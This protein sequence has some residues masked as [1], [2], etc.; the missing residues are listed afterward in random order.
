MS[1]KQIDKLIT[2]TITNSVDSYN[3]ITSPYTVTLFKKVKGNNWLISQKELDNEKYYTYTKQLLPESDTLKLRID[4]ISELK[5]KY[6]TDFT[7]NFNTKITNNNAKPKINNITAIVFDN[8]YPLEVNEYIEETN[9]I[10][11]GLFD[12][13]LT[14]EEIYDAIQA[15]EFWIELNF[16]GN[17]S[18]CKLEINNFNVKIGFTNDLEIEKEAIYNRLEDLFDDIDLNIDTINRTVYPENYP[19][20][21]LLTTTYEIFKTK[22][23]Q[24][25]LTKNDIGIENASIECFINDIYIGEPILTGTDG[26]FNI[27][28][29]DMVDDFNIKCIFKGNSLMGSA[30]LNENISI[31][32]Y[33][34]NFSINMEETEYIF[35]PSQKEPI[36]L[37]CSFNK[38]RSI[39]DNNPVNITCS[40][41]NK[42]NNKTL[43]S[44]KFK[45]VTGDLSINFNTYNAT[46]TSN[47]NAKVEVKLEGNDKYN[48]VVMS[49]D[50]S[51]K[52]QTDITYVEKTPKISLVSNYNN[53]GDRLY[54]KVTDGSTVIKCGTCN[55]TINGKTI[56]NITPNENGNFVTG[57]LSTY[58]IS[59]LSTDKKYPCKVIYSGCNHKKDGVNTIYKSVNMSFDLNVYG[60][61]TKTVPFTKYAGYEEN[62]NDGGYRKWYTLGSGDDNICI[63]GNASNPIGASGGTH[64]YPRQLACYGV[65]TGLSNVSIKG[66]TVTYYDANYPKTDSMS[67]TNSC[68]ISKHKNQCTLIMDTASKIFTDKVAIGN[69]S[70]SKHSFSVSGSWTPS[71]LNNLVMILYYGANVN[72]N[73]GRLKVAG[74]CV[75]LTYKYSQVITG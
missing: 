43:N 17:G 33:T 20:I 47:I 22:Y 51:L 46:G 71:Q 18:N 62:T 74:A 10:E 59:N 1:Q 13:D 34:A 44:L 60:E 54:F 31:S 72:S 67:S 9:T 21:N 38:N 70:W 73:V 61:R 4:P 15:S 45:N 11:C 66:I 35:T 75:T 49:K 27:P 29:E 36:S 24:C 48:Q 2:Q 30:S 3:T 16:D 58:G 55:I 8:E 28:I 52:Y 41:I 7:I 25:S 50:I 69:K 19:Q 40:L 14:D 42:T 68:N 32:K 26:V 65:N 39:I 64:K 6:I 53:Y 37:N 56:S 12:I 23:I 5:Y 63:C 57:I